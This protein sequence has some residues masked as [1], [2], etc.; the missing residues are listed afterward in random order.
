MGKINTCKY[1]HQ[2]ILWV[3][4]PAGGWVAVNFDETIDPYA[5]QYDPYTMTRHNTV[6]P[7]GHLY[8]KKN[9]NRI[10]KFRQEML[11]YKDD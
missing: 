4:M 3:R 6:C 11:P 8:K 5:T 9:T 7:K 2:S 1:C 10:N